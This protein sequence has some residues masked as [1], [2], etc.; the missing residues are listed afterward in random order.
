MSNAN[1]ILILQGAR[2]LPRADI[3][4]QNKEPGLFS[5]YSTTQLGGHAIRAALDATEVD[6]DLIGHVVMGMAQHS[7]RDTLEAAPQRGGWR[8]EHAVPLLPVRLPRPAR[9]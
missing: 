7:H 6:T 5:R 2:R 9:G 1:S 8:R 3:L 4:V